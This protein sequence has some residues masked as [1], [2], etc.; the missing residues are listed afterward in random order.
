MRILHVNSYYAAGNFYKNLFDNQVKTG[1]DIKVYVP[2][3]KNLIYK[4]DYGDYTTVSYNHGKYD[5][6]FFHLK[7]YKIWQDF[8]NKI[9]YKNYDI[10][11][12]HSLFSNGYIA[13]K[14]NKKHNIPYIVAVRDTDTNIFFKRMIHLRPLGVDIL[15]RASKVIFLSESYRDNTI[16]KY[17]PKKLQKEIKQKSHVIPNG[18]D[19]YWLN[20]KQQKKS[21]KNKRLSLVF[22]GSISA[23]KNV[24][25]SIAT[26]KVL[27]NRGYDVTLTIIGPIKNKKIYHK[28]KDEP[29]VDYVGEKTKEEIKRIYQTKDIFV[30][31]SIRETFGLVYAEAMSQS[32]PVIYTEG[33][34]FDCQFKEGTVGYHVKSKDEND[35]ADKI[36]LILKNYDVIAKN[37]Y[38]NVGKYNWQDIAL[39]YKKVY[40][41]VEK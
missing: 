37:C 17:I 20:N 26:C 19:D 32:L 25:R 41:E 9:N 18:I 16:D 23:R 8:L 12:A 7:H 35:I 30:M 21:R 3:S 27:K 5:R 34:G 13:Y 22:T 1:L 11:H 24:L 36:E 4:K 33:Q 29:L 15:K 14:L 38:N 39:T 28:F 31:P 6:I 10:V 2:V 40:S